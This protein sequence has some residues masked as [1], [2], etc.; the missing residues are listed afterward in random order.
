[1]DPYFH[2]VPALLHGLSL[3]IFLALIYVSRG[4][5]HPSW[6]SHPSLDKALHIRPP[7]G[8]LPSLWIICSWASCLSSL[9]R[10]YGVTYC[11][12]GLYSKQKICIGKFL[13]EGLW[14][15]SARWN[16]QSS[17]RAIQ[18]RFVVH[19]DEWKVTINTYFISGED[20]IRLI[21][22]Q[23]MPWKDQ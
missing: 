7:H 9:T 8:L 16:I 17:P 5:Y 23:W 19:N 12:L 6:G 20:V 4:K 10:W 11:C 21:R 14:A 13:Y 18:C 15:G 22:R 1:M 3:C 2:L